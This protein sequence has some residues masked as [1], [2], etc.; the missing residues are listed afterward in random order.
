[1]KKIIC[2]NCLSTEIKKNR[3][4]QT[5][6]FGIRTLHTCE[7]CGTSFSETH[8]TFLFC[9]KKPILLIIN[10]LKCLTEG[11]GIN[12]CC[13]I[14]NISKN[15]LYSWIEKFSEIK[16]VLY[17]FSICQQFIDMVIEGDELYTKVNKNLP[18]EDSLGWT[19]VLIERRSRF[20]WYMKCDK[21]DKQL[22][23][24]AMRILYDIVKQSQDLKLFTD[25]ERRYA[26]MLF[27][28]CYDLIYTSRRPKKTLKK[29]VK[30]RIKNKGSQAHKCG[31][32]RKK[33]QQPKKEHPEN[34]DDIKNSDI[35][36]NHVEGFN[37]SLRR[38]CSAY[39]RRSNT[40]AKEKDRLQ[41][42]LD[43]HW[44]RH[45]FIEKHFTTKKNPAVSLKIIEK[46]FTFEEVFNLKICA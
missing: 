38:K 17:L 36:A 16:K 21:K 35:H 15:T 32:K 6:S 40:Y 33:Y 28:I 12:A 23:K 18:Q 20:I 29:G 11:L 25:G 31:P 8:S 42:R 1:M 14:A 41:Q 30:V 19:I 46:E 5:K 27:E 37:A 22:F 34:I 24:D 39:R 13:R 2:P 3:Q 4:Y 44:I 7:N 26:N 10:T 43:L 9:I 45:N